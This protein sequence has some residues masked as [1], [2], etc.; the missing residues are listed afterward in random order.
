MG[1][2]TLRAE[3]SENLDDMTEEPGAPVR[4]GSERSEERFGKMTET[5]R[6]DEDPEQKKTSHGG[7]KRILPD[8]AERTDRDTPERQGAGQSGEP[9]LVQPEEASQD[10]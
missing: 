3:R 8:G 9:A 7:K 6:R 5:D 10:S 4:E 1:N 2:R